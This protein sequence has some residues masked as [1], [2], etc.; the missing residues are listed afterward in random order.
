VLRRYGDAREGGEFSDQNDGDTAIG[1]DSGAT[2]SLNFDCRF[3]M[4]G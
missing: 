1:L 4:G 3:P 2:A